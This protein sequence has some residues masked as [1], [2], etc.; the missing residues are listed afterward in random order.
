M[1]SMKFPQ[2]IH[3]AVCTL[4]ASVFF[5]LAC[6]LRFWQTFIEATGGFLS[7]NIPLYAATFLILVLIF[8]AA[9]TSVPHIQSLS[10]VRAARFPA[11]GIE[12]MRA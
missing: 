2:N 11:G 8:N 10:L 1:V 7:R 5:V 4:T 9:L 3:M 6:N 12:P